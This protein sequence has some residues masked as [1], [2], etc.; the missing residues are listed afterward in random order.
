MNLDYRRLVAYARDISAL[1]AA[2]RD[3]LPKPRSLSHFPLDLVQADGLEFSGIYEDGWLSPDSEVILGAARS[4]E[5]VRLRGYV[6]VLPGAKAGGEML[7]TING[8]PAFRV[9][10]PPGSFN[11][12][13]PVAVPGRTTRVALHF[14]AGGL[15]PNGDG[16]PAAAKLESLDIGPTPAGPCQF[17]TAGS[18]R[19]PCEGVDQDGWAL[20][21]DDVALPVNP[22]VYALR[23]EFEY[24]GWPG[25]PAQGDVTVSIEGQPARTLALK[26]G[27]NSVT[28]PL[29]PG[30]P[31]RHVHLQ[32]KGAFRLPAPDGRERAFR[33]LSVE[34]IVA[35]ET[36]E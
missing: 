15:L 16:R 34:E 31:V 36:H 35:A 1:S 24:P 17:A 20:A 26:P 23:F 30:S 32:S 3:A 8:G 2:D 22:S 12:V 21:G 11:W 25:I 27:T 28:L 5:S 13:V 14:T 6:P 9:S 33:L 18:P 10:A 7:I 19:F 4:G 29:M